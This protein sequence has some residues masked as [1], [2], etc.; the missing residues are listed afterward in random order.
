MTATHAPPSRLRPAR[1]GRHARRAAALALGAGLAL[2]ACGSTAVPE[3][4]PGPTTATTEAPGPAPSVPE[5]CTPETVT[6]S[7]RPPVGFDPAVIAPGSTMAEIRDRG[8]LRVG[9][10][11]STLLFSIVDP[12]TDEFEGFDIEIAE[13]VAIALFGEDGPGE[14]PSGTIEFVAIPYG[15]RVDVLAPEG[16]G[17]PLVDMVVD[18]FTINCEREGRIDFSTEYFTSSQKL[19]VPR[20]SQVTSIDDLTPQERV[21]AAAGSTSIQNLEALEGGPEP[22]PVTDQA[23]CLVLIQRGEVDAIS[24]DDTILAGMVAQDPNLQIV[25]EGFSAE[26]Y[27]IGVPPGR[28]DWL[29]Y[30]NGVLER[31]RSDGT[32]AA[33]YEDILLEPMGLDAVPAPPTARYEAEG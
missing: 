23:D 31:V 15:E 30:V 4:L 29:R 25:G 6:E 11:T 28:E 32:W 10:D 17:E 33:L 5:G 9:V 24:T 20:N 16:D 1:R 26:P 14:P 12:L 8:R 3:S 21:C 13:R 22:V 27:G 7:L 18:T 2:A 19:L